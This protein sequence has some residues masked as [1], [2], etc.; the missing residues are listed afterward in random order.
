MTKL[1]SDRVKDA[2]PLCGSQNC[3]MAVDAIRKSNLVGHHDSV[4]QARIPAERQFSAAR[5]FVARQL[6]NFCSA[7]GGAFMADNDVS[8]QVN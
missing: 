4:A 8:F 6:E 5:V 7:F 1:L 3:Q 2:C